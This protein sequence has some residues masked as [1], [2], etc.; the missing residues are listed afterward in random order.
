MA[1]A[2]HIYRLGVTGT[3]LTGPARLT[4]TVPALSLTGVL[5]GPGAALLVFHSSVTGRWQPVP[6]VYDPA[7]R[8]ITA[9]ITH[10]SIWAV[11]RLDPG[12]IL[13]AATSALKGLHRRR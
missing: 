13:A 2:G 9:T 3:S 7:S 12:Q 11:L 8:T 4:L 6:A 5:A 1:F 10:L